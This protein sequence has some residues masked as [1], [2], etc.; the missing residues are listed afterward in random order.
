[1]FEG[2]FRYLKVECTDGI[3]RIALDRP[4]LNVLNIEMLGE[5]NGILE[6]IRDDDTLR[7]LVISGRGKVFSAGVEV[8][9][10][11]PDRA[12]DMTATFGRTFAILGAI[13]IPTVAIVHG[14]AFGGGCE[15]ATACDVVLCAEGARLGQPEIK[16]GAI[17]PVAAATFP[18]LCGLKRTFEL[19]LVGEPIGAPEAVAA[20]LVTRAVS[21]DALEDEAGRLVAALAGASAPVLRALK[22]TILNGI[23]RPRGEALRDAEEACATMLVECPDAEEGMR[24]FLEKRPPS[25]SRA[26][27]TA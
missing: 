17:A 19:L 4:P 18:G 8:A 26:A 15:V 27:T 21:D 14:V 3:V 1:M 5:L 11:L 10:H 25:W 7:V 12:R 20:G 23:G 6:S 22:R 16:L 2:P 24:A 13:S 9:E